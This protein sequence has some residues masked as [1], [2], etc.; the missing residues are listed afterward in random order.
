MTRSRYIPEGST[1]YARKGVDAIV[2][3]YTTRAGKL[4]AIA[5]HGKSAKSDW[6]YCFRSEGERQAKSDQHLHNISG[7]AERMKERQEKRKAFRHVLKVGD[8]LKA[9]WGYDQTNIDYYEVTAVVS[10]HTV[11]VQEIGSISRETGWLQGDCV[12]SPGRFIGAPERKRVL[13]G[14]C[15]KFKS[16]KYA[17]PVEKQ[18]IPGIPG[19]VIYPTAHWTAYA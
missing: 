4:A 15:I 11:E 12:P 2:Y 13:E 7:H 5:Y 6:H 1:P 17:Y 19:V 8:V 16:Y 9:S 3:W 18:T 14:N 10:G